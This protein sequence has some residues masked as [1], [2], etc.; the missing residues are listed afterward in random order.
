MAGSLGSDSG[1]R[2]HFHGFGVERSGGRVAAFLVAAPD[3][4]QHRAVSQGAGHVVVPQTR[5]L[6]LTVVICEYL[7]V[8]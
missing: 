7:C 4:Q 5:W 8:W 3:K 6:P 2:P 1:R